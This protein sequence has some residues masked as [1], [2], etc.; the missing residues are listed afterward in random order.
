MVE[1][2][3]RV[4][5]S[6]FRLRHLLAVDREEAVDEDFCRLLEPG[7]VEH[8]R[9]KE[10]MKADD[11]LADEVVMF[12]LRGQGCGT[13][14]GPVRCGA[15]APVR[16]AVLRQ[17]PPILQLLPIP[18]APVLER[19]QVADGRV[20]PDVEELVLVAGDLEAEVGGGA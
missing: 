16:S 12:H 5:E 8:P 11:V 2:G 20:D 3:S 6:A 17:R 19:G 13:A 15:R 7:D 18:V 4:D 1:V 10:A 14:R 9:P